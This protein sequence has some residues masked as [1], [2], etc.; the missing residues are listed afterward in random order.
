MESTCYRND[1]YCARRF[2]NVG[3]RAAYTEVLQVI[4]GDAVAEEV[5]QSI[6]EHASV[7]VPVKIA[8]VLPFPSGQKTQQLQSMHRSSTEMQAK[9][10]EIVAR[11]HV[12]VQG[13]EKQAP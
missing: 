1:Q 8:S 13:Q 7:T 4:D 3:F 2:C 9:A 10:T 11:M 12:V 6:L 5:E